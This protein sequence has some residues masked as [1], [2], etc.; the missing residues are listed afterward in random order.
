VLILVDDNWEAEL[1]SSFLRLVG[2]GSTVVY[3][4]RNEDVARN[5][6]PA[7]GDRYQL[8][9]L[10]TQDGLELLTRLAPGVSEHLEEA[11][12]LVR[13][14][15]GLPLAIVVAGGI[16]GSYSA[17]VH[18][19]AGLLAELQ[20]GE[21]LL[22]SA[23]PTDMLQLTHQTR[24]L[25]VAA[26]FERSTRILSVEQRLR[27]AQLGLLAPKPA[28]FAIADAAAGWDTD[29]PTAARELE[30]MAGLG[31]VQPMSDGRI[32]MH[33]ILNRFA[34]SILQEL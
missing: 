16:L 30:V 21:R 5:L 6:V 19:V 34:A 9:E 15:G 28:S 32:Q 8:E 25:T 1:A 4:S 2:E 18:G 12:G 17:S 23:V 22:R 29:V 10:T 13:A 7:A 26:L 20:N 31:L 14:L 27:F 24:N 11:A 33:A 3:T